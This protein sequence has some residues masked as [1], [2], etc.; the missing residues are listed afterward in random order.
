MTVLILG[1]YGFIGAEIMRA[2][3]AAGFDVVGLGR[4]VATGARLVPGARFIGAD[5]A[6]LVTAEAWA[7]HLVGVDAIINAAGALQDGGR[8]DL[9]A[10]HHCSIVALVAAAEN[11]DV[12]RF[13][14]ISAPGA[15]IGA[16]TEFLRTKAAGDGAV[17][18][19]SLDWI[20]L[21]PGL[22]IG[23]GAYGGTAL[24]RMLA[25]LPL[26]TPLIHAQSQVQTVALD[27]VAA[28]AIAALTGE[29]ATRRDYDL[30][31]ETP[32]R[33]R[34][35]VRALRR[36]IGF[37]PARIE[38]DLPAWAAAP[39]AALA[40]V[41][42]ALGWRSPLRSTALRVM[43][44]NVQGDPAPWRAATGASLKSLNE[45]LA[46]MP[47]TAQERVFA[48]AQAALPIMVITLG[49]FWIASGV[50]GGLQLD[51]AAALLPRFGRASADAMVIGGA[52]ID[53]LI[54]LAIFYRPSA[55]LGAIASVVIALAYLVAGTLLAPLLWAD[56]LG[57]YVKIVPAIVLGLCVA[58]MLEER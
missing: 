6:R 25:G 35:I 38:P 1:G 14:Q 41:A 53:V 58:L 55:R 9:G 54:G 40:D 21:K 18:A 33:L 3:M 28:A 20:V 8:D 4:S 12:K 13:V 26:A 57:P 34:E 52:V 19:S 7:P 50:I 5:M 24:L 39:V 44:E 10:I 43:G 47:G 2:A 45:T 27:D 36:Q 56:P 42:G 30:V 16:T 22:V 48:R 15:A 51:K 32:H 37:A 29:V 46:A 31:E 17:R 11:A 23:R 49:L